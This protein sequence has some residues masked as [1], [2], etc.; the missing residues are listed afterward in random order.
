MRFNKLFLLIL[1]V[2]LS[3][4][5]G[6]VTKHA[7]TETGREHPFEADYY[8]MLG[9]DSFIS[10]QWE[11]TLKYYKKALEQDPKSLYIRTQMAHV[12][13]RKG[14]VSSALTM[15]EGVLKDA[16][17]DSKAL[18]LASEIFDSSK[19]TSDA[20]N[21]LK[22]ALEVAPDD[23]DTLMFLGRLYYHND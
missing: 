5:S 9:Y 22:K 15:I 1:T 13:Y 3:G 20:I 21:A 4:C 12:L 18:I 10:E 7:G 23:K 17:Y 19:R 6:V 16:P 2:I 11:D 14:D 8:Y